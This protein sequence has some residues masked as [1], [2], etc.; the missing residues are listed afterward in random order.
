MVRNSQTDGTTSPY[1]EESAVLPRT[2]GVGFNVSTSYEDFEAL[3][4]GVAGTGRLAPAWWGGHLRNTEP[5]CFTV[6]LVL[7]GLIS[8]GGG[9]CA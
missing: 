7:Q 2:A 9:R 3:S 8:R 4:G 1:V 6:V 5:T